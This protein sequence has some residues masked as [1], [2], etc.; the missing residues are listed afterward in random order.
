MSISQGYSYNESEQVT[1]A[2]AAGDR[3]E[4]GGESMEMTGGGDVSQDY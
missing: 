4:E 2:A 3:M 1:A